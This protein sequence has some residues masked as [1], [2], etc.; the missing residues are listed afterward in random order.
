MNRV[1]IGVL[2]AACLQ[3]PAAA[4]VFTVD[5]LTD[6]GAGA[7]LAGDLRYCI[8]QANANDGAADTITFSVTGAV[9]LTS[10]LPELRTNMAIEGPGPSL[11]TVRRG[12]EDR[13]RIFN[14]PGSPNNNLAVSLSGLTIANGYAGV[15]DMWPA[16]GGGILN[17][18]TLSVSNSVISGN[19][20]EGHGGGIANVGA[21][22]LHSVTVSNNTT[23]YSGDGGGIYNAN[24][25]A[26]VQATLT[27]SNS[28]ISDNSA[29]V[30]AGISNGGTLSVNNSTVSNNSA[31][32]GG[33]GIDNGGTLTISNSTISANHAVTGEIDPP[34][35]GGGISNRATLTITSSTIAGN[36]ATSYSIWGEP[37][38]GGGIYGPATLRNT[39]LAGNSAADGPDIRGSIASLGHNLVGNTQGA[40]GLHA[41]DMLNANPLLGPLH[42]NGGLTSTHALL[43]G[44]P[45]INAGDPAAVAGAGGVPSFDQR[46]ALFTRVYA[47]RID[48]GAFELQPIAPALPGDFNGDG[49]VDAADYVVWRKNNGTQ[50]GYNIWRANFGATAAGV[51]AVARSDTGTAVPEPSALTLAAIAALG[52]LWCFGRH[53]RASTQRDHLLFVGV[54]CLLKTTAALTQ[55]AV[56]N[57]LYHCEDHYEDHPILCVG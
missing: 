48:I 44:S 16:Y 5:R 38:E 49:T 41:T 42:D 13:Y 3:H 6:T 15:T 22:T 29:L 37:S 35:N 40:S 1:F 20:V 25:S 23:S 57:L 19:Q 32:Y 9:N 43:S 31:Y 30:G 10:A 7:G 34:A 50:E 24:L 18:G 52:V 46:G 39:I 2:I 21:M 45:A 54:A 28:T 4:A 55:S 26:G 8:T 11:L 14:V 51:A 27:I 36:S 53:K 47:D 17:G 12:S 56:L 33:G